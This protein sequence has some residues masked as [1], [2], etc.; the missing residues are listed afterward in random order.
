MNKKVGEIIL[1]IEKTFELNYNYKINKVN[2][3]KL[4]QIGYSRIPIYEG[5]S[6]NLIDILRMKDLVGVDSIHPS[7]LNELDIQLTEVQMLLKIL[8]L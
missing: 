5:D 1:P 4:I 6:N 3:D 7:Q 8:S 2:L